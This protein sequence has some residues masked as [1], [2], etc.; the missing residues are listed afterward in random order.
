[1]KHFLF[2]LTLSTL[3]SCA[4]QAPAPLRYV[5][6]EVPKEVITVNKQ[7]SASKE[8][9]RGGWYIG[10]E[11]FRPAPDVQHYLSEAQK[12]AGHP[13]M[14]NVD[15]K[16]RVPFAFDLLFFGYNNGTDVV[17]LRGE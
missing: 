14:Q 3:A 12:D 16:A 17:S 11:G 2:L 15:I 10:N 4:T 1:M 13:I 7:K 5:S 6:L 9:S 8:F